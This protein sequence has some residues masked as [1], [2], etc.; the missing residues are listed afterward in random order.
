MAR[1]IDAEKMPND[2]FFEDLSNKEKCKVIQW[3]LQAPRADVKEVKRG[4]WERKE[5]DNVYW[6]VCSECKDDTPRNKHGGWSFP[7]YCSNCGADM[8]CKEE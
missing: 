2:K 8:R 5:N 7:H 6:Y 3:L 1:Y 4:H